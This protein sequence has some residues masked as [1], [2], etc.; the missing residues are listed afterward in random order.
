[1]LFKKMGRAQKRKELFFSS[2]SVECAKSNECH[3]YKHTTQ[4]HKYFVFGNFCF[5][6]IHNVHPFSDF[7]KK[8]GG[9]QRTLGAPQ[10]PWCPGN[11]VHILQA[12]A[13]LIS[14]KC[15]ILAVL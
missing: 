15:F 6:V 13:L 12:P 1:M 9:C 10:R 5:S 2:L 14:S 11:W 8:I 7:H 3:L 4:P